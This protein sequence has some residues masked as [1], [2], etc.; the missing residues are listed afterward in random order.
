MFTHTHTHYRKPCP[1]PSFAQASGVEDISEVEAQVNADFLREEESAQLRYQATDEA[2]RQGR[3]F[4]PGATL[5][6]KV[7]EPSGSGFGAAAA[8]GERLSRLILGARELFR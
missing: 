7:Y 1:L 2:V 8:S 3:V 5:S 4:P 6:L